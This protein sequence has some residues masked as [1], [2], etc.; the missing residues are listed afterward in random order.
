MDLSSVVPVNASDAS[1]CVTIR[2]ADN[3]GSPVLFLHNE[4]MFQYRLH[5]KI[6]EVFC[7]GTNDLCRLLH[8]T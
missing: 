5:S 2:H 6:A 7:R 1:V 3:N 4:Q 8:I